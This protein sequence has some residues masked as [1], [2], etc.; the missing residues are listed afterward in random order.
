MQLRSLEWA[1]ST[2]SPAF[3]FTHC[4]FCTLDVRLMRLSLIVPCNATAGVAVDLV[5][6]SRLSWKGRRTRAMCKPSEW[7]AVASL[8]ELP[9]RQSGV[10]R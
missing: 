8:V 10:V 6:R 4:I 9:T 1:A 5:A 3:L 2:L 7:F